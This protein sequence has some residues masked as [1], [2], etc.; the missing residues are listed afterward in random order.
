M[1][2]SSCFEQSECPT[3]LSGLLTFCFPP[4]QT[5]EEKPILEPDKEETGELGTWGIGQFI[6]LGQA[7]WQ[8]WS[9]SGW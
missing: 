3:S 4:G 6:S 9:I 2:G 1:L 5:E 8:A 7:D